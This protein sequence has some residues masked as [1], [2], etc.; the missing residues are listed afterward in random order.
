MGN[1]TSMPDVDGFSRE[2]I[3]RLEKLKRVVAVMD[4]DLSGEVDFKEFVMGLAQFAIRDYDR[5]SKLEFIFRIYDMDRDGYISNN[6]LFQVLKNDDWKELNGSTASTNQ[7]LE[8]L[9][10]M[11]KIRTTCT[12]EFRSGRLGASQ[13]LERD[14]GTLHIFVKTEE[15]ESCCSQ[16]KYQREVAI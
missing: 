5:K 14:G 3:S 10:K 16:K 9:D 2:E 11:K 6:E 1:G 4:S 7:S 13:S 8:T 15:R 12:E